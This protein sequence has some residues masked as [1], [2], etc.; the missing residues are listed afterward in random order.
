[1]FSRRNAALLG[2]LT[3]LGALLDT[4]APGIGLASTSVAGRATKTA[5]TK[6][7]TKTTT[8]KTTTKATKA[9]EW[10]V[11]AVSSTGLAE[12][13][14]CAFSRRDL[15]QVWLH[16]DSGDGAIV[17]PVDIRSGKAGRPVTLDGIDVVDLEDIAIT[18]N[19]DLILADIGD[20][21][22][23]RKSVQLYRFAEPVLNATSAQATRLD[24]RY[25]DGPHNAEALVVEPDGSAAYIFTKE[26]SGVAAVFRADLTATTT[27]VM[28]EIGNV[29]ITGEVG[30]KPN[31]I[32]AA[33]A[34]GQT[35]IVRSYQ[36]GYVLDV[37]NGGKI[38]D[39]PRAAP[40]RFSLPLMVQG[41]ALCV[42]SNGQTLVTAS[43]S[44]GRATF[45]LA[46]GT[47]PK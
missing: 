21:A 37:P 24:V 45:A 3:L 46:V 14:G 35:V 19:G 22:V 5:T 1:M 2:G 4:A 20:N 43:E 33:D 27:Q 11:L 36:F 31:L 38:A 7:I 23:A 32:S 9:A 26:P 17:V 6:P 47:V 30:I 8:P 18:A 16:N 39:A 29:K 41:E 44:Q 12:V 40:R 25:P 34:V 28:T 42:S 13:S 15:N 10:R